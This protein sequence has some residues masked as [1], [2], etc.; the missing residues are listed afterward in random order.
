[1]AGACG[2]TLV[3]LRRAYEQ[4]MPMRAELLFGNEN[5]DKWMA[6]A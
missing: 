4:L 6:D 5:D 1:V 2:I 3:T